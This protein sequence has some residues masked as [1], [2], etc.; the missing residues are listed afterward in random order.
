M[1]NFL[2]VIASNLTEHSRTTDRREW[3]SLSTRFACLKYHLKFGSMSHLSTPPYF[4]SFIT[5]QSTFE[6]KLPKTLLMINRTPVDSAHIANRSLYD[7]PQRRFHDNGSSWS[8]QKMNY[9]TV[10]ELDAE[11]GKWNDQLPA[12][13]RDTEALPG[14]NQSC[15][16]RQRISLRCTYV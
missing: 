1:T 5:L 15:F 12:Y 10:M 6:G 8:D 3:P 16:V 2:A 13:L 4:Y 7:T 11:L 14:N 9:N